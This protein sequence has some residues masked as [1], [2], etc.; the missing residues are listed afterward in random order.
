M[1]KPELNEKIKAVLKGFYGVLKSTDQYLRFT[2]FTG[3]TK[4]SKVSVFSDL[5]NLTNISLINRFSSI[6]GITERELLTQFEP[7]IKALGEAQNLTYDQ[8]IAELKKMYDGYHFSEKS[9]DI[10]N[11]WSLLNSFYSGRF[12]Y[13][14]F[15]SGTPTMLVNMLKNTDLDLPNLEKDVIITQKQLDDYDISSPAPIPLLYQTGY[16]TIKEYFPGFTEYRLGFPNEEV[17]YGFNQLR[18]TN[19]ELR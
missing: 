18:I 9:E 11:P 15:A 14:W 5:N 16:L 4:F 8:T 13:E 19:D 1:T 7:E 6:C 10:Y 2:L 3:V 17:K 12:V